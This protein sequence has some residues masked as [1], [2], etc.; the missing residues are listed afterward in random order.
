MPCYASNTLR[1]MLATLESSKKQP[2]RA[3]TLLPATL[4]SRMRKTGCARRGRRG[5]ESRCHHATCCELFLR[6]GAGVAVPMRTCSCLQDP[7]PSVATPTFRQPSQALSHSFPQ[8]Q[9]RCPLSFHKPCPS[10]LSGPPSLLGC[11]RL[12]PSTIQRP[13][14]CSSVLYMMQCPSSVRVRVH[15]T[16]QR[17]GQ[18]SEHWG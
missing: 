15:C 7:A 16:G 5:R 1:L 9:S 8:A 6:Q 17:E 14:T 4:K 11:A 13:F 10:V 2:S 3:A 12:P 18:G